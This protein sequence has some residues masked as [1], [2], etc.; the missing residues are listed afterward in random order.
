MPFGASRF[1]LR[2]FITVPRRRPG[3]PFTLNV[4][5]YRTNENNQSPK[6]EAYP[7]TWTNT[8]DV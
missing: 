3:I 2:Y 8:P 6:L 1:G 7:D 5:N 4:I